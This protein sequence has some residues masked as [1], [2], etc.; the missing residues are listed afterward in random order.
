MATRYGAVNTLLDPEGAS[1]AI[2]VGA[3]MTVLTAPAHLGPEEIP[4]VLA[5]R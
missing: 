3:G 5:P 1:G 4:V 2:L